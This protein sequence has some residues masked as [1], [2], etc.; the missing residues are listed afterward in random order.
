MKSKIQIINGDITTQKVD[1]IVNAANNSLL[2]GG[3]VDGAIHTAAGVELLVECRTLNGCQ[4][5]QAK[6]TQGYELT[7]KYVI[8]TVGPVW[9]GG[10]RNEKELLANCYKNCLQLAIENNIKSI[11]FPSIST[12]AY[13]YSIELASAVALTEIISFL[14]TNNE[15]DKIIIVC[16]GN[17]AFEMYQRALNEM[18]SD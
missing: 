4:T 3:G 8:H 10:G 12:G 9:S 18:W 13:G 2:G 15:I 6:I 1:A 17:R 7:A 14:K 11:A 5:G 16:F